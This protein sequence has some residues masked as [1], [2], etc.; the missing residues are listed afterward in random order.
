MRRLVAGFSVA[1]LLTGCASFGP[2]TPPPLR[3]LDYLHDDLGSLLIA[4]DLP[5]G[6]GPVD[7]PQALSFDV[8]GPTPKHIKAVLAQADADEVTGNLPPP[9]TGR[10]YYL[11]DFAPA[12][13]A[14]IRAVQQA[15]RAGNVAAPDVK[16]TLAPRLCRSEATVDL[17][18]V[19]VSVLVALPGGRPLAPLIDHQLLADQMAQSGGPNLPACS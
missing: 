18:Q 4:Y 8:G 13:Q 12:D 14:A 1:L 15:A 11:Y 9:A 19:T 2:S 7:G 5:R 16:M 17:K 6:I 3:T 10:A